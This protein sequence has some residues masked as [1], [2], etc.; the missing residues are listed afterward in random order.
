MGLMKSLPFLF[1][2]LCLSAFAEPTP[3]A[4]K[5]DVDQIRERYW[6][7]GKESEMG[8][9]QRRLY[10][11]Q[12]HVELSIHGGILPGDPL[13]TTKTIGLDLGYHLSERVAVHGRYLAASPQ[14]SS[15]SNAV[16]AAG[17]TPSTNE[18]VEFLG[19]EG[20]L[21]FAHGKLATLGSGMFYLDGYLAGGAGR[22]IA[23]TGNSLAITAGLG[24]Q[25]RVA[26]WLAFNLDYRVLI[27]REQLV[28]KAP[29]N[30]GADLGTR[31]SVNHSVTL[32]LSFYFNLFGD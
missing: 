27:F 25:L 32:G 15:A 17:G 14:P 30:F 20:R 10:P 28:S 22:L 23:E 5:V 8:V 18:P 31:S 9:I 19:L 3:P 21:S 12:G 24:H 6:S 7:K 13:L 26:R 4:Q 11:R 2:V 1:F 16:T 29:G